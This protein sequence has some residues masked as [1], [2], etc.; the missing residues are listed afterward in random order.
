M[1]PPVTPVTQEGTIV[2]TF[3]YMSPEQVEGKEIDGRSDIFSL[4][5][6][7]YE[8]WTGQRAFAGKS[9]LSV[10]SS[11]LEK[12]PA[13]ITSLRPL[14]PSALERTIRKCLEKAPDDRWQSA[15][16]LASQLKWI[17]EEGLGSGQAPAVAAA[18]QKN[19]RLIYAL[20]AI[21]AAALVLV[22]VIWARPARQV[23]SRVVRLG[24]SLP[25]TSPIMN[26]SVPIALSRDGRRMVLVVGH[27][28]VSQIAVRDLSSIDIKLLPGTEGASLPFLSPD[29][30][31][32]GFFADGKL[33]KISVAGGP[34]IELATVQNFA[35]GTWLS[36]G[37][38]VYTPDWSGGMYRIS[39]SGGKPEPLAQP[40]PGKVQDWQW[41]PQALPNG[42]ILFTRKTGEGSQESSIAVFSRKTGKF[43]TLIEKASDAH[44][45][46]S[47]HLLYLSQGS[48]MAVP[49]DEKKLTVTGTPLPVL[50]GVQ[51]TGESAELA[52][53]WDGTLAYVPGEPTGNHNLLV[54]VDRSGKE[55][56]LPAQP[57]AYEDV[58]LSPDG[59]LLAMTIIGEQQWSV[60]I[61]DLQQRTLN[62]F[63][64][65]GDNRDPVWTADSKRL[66]YASS[67][68]GGKGL[69]WKPVN[70]S[71]SEEEL[72]AADSQPFPG[73]VSK[74][75]HYLTYDLRASESTAVYLLPLQ[76]ERKPRLLFSDRFAGVEVIS[77]DGKWIAYESA[78]SGRGEIYVREF[79]SGD[80]KR[81]I[82]TDG[83][84][85]PWWSADGHE[86]FYRSSEPKLGD[87]LF[88]IAV[89]AGKE[90]KEFVT[91]SPRPLFRFR[92]AE[93]GHDYVPARDAQ[94]F[95][96]IKQPESETSATQVNVV[97]NWAKE[98]AG[99]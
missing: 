23:E 2:G 80:G 10:A 82:S 28:G 54:S 21:T 55:T 81:Q 44:Y 7:L 49:F 8:M 17:S 24:I 43:K 47:G 71:G 35:G 53:A 34:A 61:Y 4:G 99:K 92:Y 40:G 46:P 6:V 16:D 30:E 66:I 31:W 38:I 15:S 84:T 20:A 85:R 87:V 52:V 96:C 83:G 37:D 60:W 74:D 86:L 41:V 65:D 62:R 3:Q 59:N 50:Q 18:G 33:K 36:D 25:A 93:A 57:H 70:G 76:G 51:T 12:E 68:N 45:S 56:V 67:R 78:E 94:H 48:I 90:G 91:G 39:A 11:I 19:S 88:S 73:T 75:G 14:T 58:A 77:P 9:H 95:F 97:L 64:F 69:Y 1:S 79:A 5:A 22:A 72:I 27:G 63:T 42:D 98:L 32:I 89:S 13:P 26:G 29:G